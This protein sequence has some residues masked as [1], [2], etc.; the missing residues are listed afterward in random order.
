VNEVVFIEGGDEEVGTVLYLSMG[1]SIHRNA[2][3]RCTAELGII[4][5]NSTN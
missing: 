1:G 4:D 2:E 3:K 5:D